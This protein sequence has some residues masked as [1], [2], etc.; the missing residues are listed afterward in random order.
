M[1]NNRFYGVVT[2]DGVVTF[3]INELR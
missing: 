3:D 1:V 2:V